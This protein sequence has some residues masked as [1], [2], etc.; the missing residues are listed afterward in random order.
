MLPIGAGFD[1][2][3][4][5]EWEVKTSSCDIFSAVDI[6]V[7]KWKAF[8]VSWKKKWLVLFKTFCLLEKYG[9]K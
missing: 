8:T 5:T 3:Y 2:D 4:T 1:F 7:G 9:M 6:A